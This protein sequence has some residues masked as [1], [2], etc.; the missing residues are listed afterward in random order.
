M[1]GAGSAEGLC[2]VAGFSN[3]DDGYALP[4]G[5]GSGEVVGCRTVGCLLVG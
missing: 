2:H 1:L 4:S 3:L 5:V